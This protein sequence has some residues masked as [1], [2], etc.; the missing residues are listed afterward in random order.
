MRMLGKLSNENLWLQKMHATGFSVLAHVRNWQEACRP[1]PAQF[2]DAF[3][4]VEIL[5]TRRGPS[6]LTLTTMAH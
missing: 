2:V 5:A 4:T 6:Y 3:T 1:A